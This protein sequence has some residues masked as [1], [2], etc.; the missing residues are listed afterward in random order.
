M[1]YEIQKR[2]NPF[3]WPVNI[4]DAKAVQQVLK[5]RVQIIPLKKNP[6]FIAG[7]DAAFANEKVIAVACLYQYPEL[8]PVEDIFAVTKVAFPYIPGFLSFREGPAIIEAL[9]GLKIKPDLILFDGQG[10]AHPKGLGIASHIGVLLGLPT[11]GCAKSRLVGEYKGPG[12]KKGLRSL[13]TFHG[14]VVGVVLRTKDN[15]RPLFIS[16]GHR[17][18]LQTSIEIVLNCISKYRIPEPLRRADSL[19]KKMKKSVQQVR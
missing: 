10:I 2:I 7:V 13:L 19:S 3:L 12:L 4:N 9:N 15:V 17:T 16:P 5:D 11:V 1:K 14:N 18:D 8:I 6:K